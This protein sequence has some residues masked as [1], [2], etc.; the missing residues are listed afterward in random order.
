MVAKV[1]RKVAVLLVAVAMAWVGVAAAA[2]TKEEAAVKASSDWLAHVDDGKYA[3]SWTDAA[4][5]FRS[6]VSKDQWVQQVGAVR[7]PLGKL[8]ERRLK[9]KSYQTS[10]PGAP[11]GEYVVIEYATSFANKKAA[12]ETVTPT[13]D[14]DGRWRVAGY[15]IR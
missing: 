6:A 10:L 5:I 3:E 9:S 7:K 4:Q 1:R 2:E 12:V 15:F 8:I 14:R 11:D 13:R